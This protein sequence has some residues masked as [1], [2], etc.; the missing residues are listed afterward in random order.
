MEY[1]CYKDFSLYKDNDIKSFIFF[2]LK[3]KWST[4]N[5]YPNKMFLFYCIVFIIRGCCWCWL[6]E[7]GC[8]CKLN[9]LL[10]DRDTYWSCSWVHIRFSSHGKIHNAKF[11]ISPLFLLLANLCSINIMTEYILGRLCFLYFVKYIRKCLIL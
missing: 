2:P 7:C 3:V 5:P 10:R 9:L 1:R 4:S 8:I 11:S 6:A